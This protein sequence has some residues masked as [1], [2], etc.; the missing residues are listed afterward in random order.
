MLLQAVKASSPEWAT[1]TLYPAASRRTSRLVQ[2]WTS[3]S[4]MRTVCIL[5]IKF[6][7]QGRER[8]VLSPFRLE[9]TDFGKENR[10]CN[11]FYSSVFAEKCPTKKNVTL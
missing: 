11:D 8:T 7:C 9:R 4:T 5:G 3:S 10:L 2:K 1:S 6:L